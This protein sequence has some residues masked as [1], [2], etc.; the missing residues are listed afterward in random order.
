MTRAKPNELTAPRRALQDVMPVVADGPR[1]PLHL[2]DNTNLFG[3][4]PTALA[5]IQ[6]AD[7]SDI[8]HYPPSS[9]PELREAIASYLSIQPN[10]VVLG[11][12]GDDV[13]DCAFRAFCEPGDAVAF[14]DPTFVMARYF[15]MTNSLAP[16]PVSV[17]SD[18]TTDVA[19][20]IATRAPVVYACAPNNPTG[21]Q[22]TAPELR[23]LLNEADGIVII[24]EAYAEFAGETLAADIVQHG[25]AIVVRTFSKAFGLAGLRVGYAVGTPALMLE[26]EKARGPFP[27]TNVALRAA[28]AA[29]TADLPWV[30]ARVE[31]AIAAR[32]ELVR[33]LR[34]RGFTPL[35][36]AGNFVLVPVPNARDVAQRLA[37][38][39]IAVRAFSGL[40]QIGD[41]L[42]ITVAPLDAMHR[43]ADALGEATS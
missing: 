23:V 10:E 41:A 19:A 3:A 20:L 35:A 6:A 15:A 22:P 2:A 4:P 36:S 37:A 9:G 14:P 25:R 7:A 42:R 43:V 40:A 1:A 39:G 28:T 8:V 5:V 29:V 34:T 21:L 31:D 24:D 13:I 38:I 11:C 17:R 12:G 30:Q 16:R 26:I 33:L 27:V 18:G 32:V